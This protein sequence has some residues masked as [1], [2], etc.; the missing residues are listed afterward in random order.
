[1]G[2]MKYVQ[3]RASCSG[4]R[5]PPRGGPAVGKRVPALRTRTIAPVVN[6]PA[7]RSGRP[8][9]TGRQGSAMPSFPEVDAPLG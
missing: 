1:M 4:L 8:L 6:S 7:A 9:R 5:F 3:R 2:R